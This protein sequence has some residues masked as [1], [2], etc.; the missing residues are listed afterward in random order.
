MELD[1]QSLIKVD[2]RGKLGKSG[3]RGAYYTDSSGILVAKTC[4][5]CSRVLPK[6]AFGIRNGN[7]YKYGINSECLECVSDYNR[8]YRHKSNNTEG[9]L[10]TIERNRI[11][12]RKRSS[13][14]KAQI[15]EDQ[16]KFRP[17]GTK[18]C[19]TCKEELDLSEFRRDRTRTDGLNV[20]C[21][22]CHVIAVSTSEYGDFLTYWADNGIPIEC[23][24]CLGPF[25][26]VEHIV[27]LTLDGPNDLTNMLP[28][29]R[30]C[31]RG[32]GGKHRMCMTKWLRT[33]RPDDYSEVT[34]RVM[35]YGVW[36][37]YTPVDGVS[38]GDDVTHLLV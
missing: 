18:P 32:P 21:K 23:Y 38:P 28:A 2:M 14:T 33:R 15:L 9:M 11:D 29:C 24:A 17:T 20:M 36:P 16:K 34:N 12:L 13:R 7:K 26:E 1:L 35:S 37:F 8:K 22:K 27:P 25:E 10:G 31:N 5:T 19:R 4:P 6:E 30:A 3:V